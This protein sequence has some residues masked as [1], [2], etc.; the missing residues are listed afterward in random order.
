MKMKSIKKY[1]IAILV[2]VITM[3]SFNELRAQVSILSANISSFNITPRNLLDVTIL[4]HKT[5]VQVVLSAKILAANNE[6]L[7]SVTSAHFM[8]KTGMVDIAQQN[9]SVASVTYSN[10]NQ[11]TLLK[12]SH[13]LPGGKYSYCASITAVDVS[14]E[15]CQD[16]ESES[17]AFL[18]LVFPPD[19]E[20]IET[21][22]PVLTWTHSDPFIT[23]SP[24]DY[25]RIMVADLNVGQSPEAALNTNIPIYMKNNLTAHQVQYPIDAKELQ[26]GKRY[27]WQVQ[28]IS[29]GTII[30]KTE[31]WE[32]KIK[33]PDPVKE[34]KYA[35]MKKVLDGTLYMAEGNKI[36]F[37]FDENYGLKKLHYK[38]LN[39]KQEAI[40]AQQSSDKDDRVKIKDVK[41][42]Y[43]KFVIDLN[44]YKIP[45]GIYTL[46][47]TNE[48]KE[49]YKLKFL[50]E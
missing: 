16:M 32:F 11:A 8:L 49:V 50:V 45:A 39:E 46:E 3:F 23:N 2:S 17:S 6:V 43:N 30:N 7:M 44:E 40:S 20:E 15:Y 18:Y 36:F 22:Y 34:N 14:D 9:V 24:A 48:K 28:K 47:V 37:R 29:N 25:Y 1:L 31:A 5:D 10:S 26:T 42:G 35:V 41:A 38:I 27:A 33:A 12:T 19:K 21:K 13:I 4:N